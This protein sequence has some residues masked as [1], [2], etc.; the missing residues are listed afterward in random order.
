M[1]RARN[2]P[3]L[4]AA[5][6]ERHLGRERPVIFDPGEIAECGSMVIEAGR[7][8]SAKEP[9]VGSWIGKAVES[10]FGLVP[11]PLRGRL[12]GLL[13]E[14]LGIPTCSGTAGDADKEQH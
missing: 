6:D 11:P 10:G 7:D 3:K 4:S 14:K 2:R 9:V 1:G 8:Q 12:S 5:G 13:P